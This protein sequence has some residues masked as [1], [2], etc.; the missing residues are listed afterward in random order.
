MQIFKNIIINKFLLLTVLII[1]KK[2]IPLQWN[3]LQFFMQSAFLATARWL[4]NN[5]SDATSSS[6]NIIIS[7]LLLWRGTQEH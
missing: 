3:I 4:Q 5:E 7:D 6:A 2:Q 1:H